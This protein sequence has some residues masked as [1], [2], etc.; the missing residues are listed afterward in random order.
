MLSGLATGLVDDGIS[1]LRASPITHLTFQ[2][3]AESSLQPVDAHP[4]HADAV[5]RGAADGVEADARSACRSST[6]RSDDWLPRVDFALFGVDP[7]GF[8]AARRPAAPRAAGA[9]RG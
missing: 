6:P 7:T 3:G 2:E 8:L 5:Q 4:E 9:R 1:G